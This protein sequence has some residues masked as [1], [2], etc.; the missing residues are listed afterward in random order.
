MPEA[1][2]LRPCRL[3]RLAIVDVFEQIK[4]TFT[5]NMMLE[6]EVP[7]IRHSV[8]AM[9]VAFLSAMPV[10][11]ATFNPV[12]QASLRSS[13]NAANASLEDDVIDL[14]GG[15]ITLTVVDPVSTD[16]GL[17]HIVTAST[18]G[19]ITIQ[20]GSLRRDPSADAFRILYAEPGASLALDRLNIQNGL[21]PANINGGGGI[22][23]G[24]KATASITNSTFAGNA[25]PAA[26]GGA[27]LVDG[28]SVYI[29]NSTFGGNSAFNGGAL[30]LADGTVTVVNSTFS[31]NSA[32]YYGG[33]FVANGTLMISNSIVAQQTKGDDCFA[34]YGVITSLGH[35]IDGDG[36][37]LKSPQA[38][39]LPSTD[40]KLAMMANNG[41]PTLTMALL[42]GSPAIDA[43]GSDAI[44]VDQRGAAA[45]GTRDIGAYEFNGVIKAGDYIRGGA[46][47]LLTLLPLAAFSLLRRRKKLH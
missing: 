10:H 6:T 25:A 35:N 8:A 29:A 11:A 30:T 41:G 14:G 38:G 32:N 34:Y 40:P 16:S 7:V 27:V 4:L 12:D 26:S 31:A 9:L 5:L 3:S 37:C 1:K 13:I 21:F 19:K 28:A 44:P 43:A 2:S 36:S 20:N 33:L 23:V 45:V 18:A 15:V 17:P 39:D 47:G 46:F 42:E 22:Y 24:S